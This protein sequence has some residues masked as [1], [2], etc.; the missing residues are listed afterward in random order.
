MS[1][2]N[3]KKL[4]ALAQLSIEGPAR[5]AALTDLEAIIGM[6]DSFNEAD[7]G[8]TQPMSH[9]L[10]LTARLRP[11]VAP[12]MAGMEINQAAYQALAPAAENGLYLVPQVIDSE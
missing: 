7:V 11:D 10:D 2:I 1:E 3:L 6:I 8:D 12:V 4:A 5:D 9:P